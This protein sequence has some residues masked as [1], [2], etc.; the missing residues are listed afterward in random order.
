MK[1]IVARYVE[2]GC[3]INIFK[4]SRIARLKSA[5]RQIFRRGWRGIERSVHLFARLLRAARR[6]GAKGKHGPIREDIAWPIPEIWVNMPMGVL[7]LGSRVR[8]IELTDGIAILEL[9]GSWRHQCAQ[10]ILAKIVAP[11]NFVGRG[12][13]YRPVRTEGRSREFPWSDGL[14]GR[15][16]TELV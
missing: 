15:R 13:L 10:L 3:R 16:A 7:S 4:V 14:V 1:L 11:K 6:G 9:V 5:L 2:L 12:F 8:Y